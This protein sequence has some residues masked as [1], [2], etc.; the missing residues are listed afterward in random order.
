MKITVVEQVTQDIIFSDRN[1]ELQ[2]NNLIT[3]DKI[4]YDNIL[5][6]VTGQGD[7]YT[8]GNYFNDY[9]KMIAIDLNKHQALHAD[10][11][12]IYQINFTVNLGQDGNTTKSFI[13][14]K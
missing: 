9:Y 7:D 4:T 1:K 11:K 6:I 14:E 5:K 13:I 2:F 3:Y 10:P 12:A 8:T